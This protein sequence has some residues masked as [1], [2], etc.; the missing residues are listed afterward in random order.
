MK[1]HSPGSKLSILN[2]SRGSVLV[3]SA[4]AHGIV[5][6]PM[7][8][9]ALSSLHHGAARTFIR[10]LVNLHILAG[11][12]KVLW[13]DGK[14]RA[15]SVEAKLLVRSREGKRVGFRRGLSVDQPFVH[16][17]EMRFQPAQI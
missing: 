11:K 1:F 16:A 14:F 2:R 15:D 6:C 4:P 5:E 7:L 3:S 8:S 13:P 12:V 10:T 17:P 9:L